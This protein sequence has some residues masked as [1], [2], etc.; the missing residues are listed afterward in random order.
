M[1][2]S[3]SHT[4]LHTQQ[5]HSSISGGKPLFLTCSVPRLLKRTRVM[6]LLEKNCSVMWLLKVMRRLK[7]RTS[8][9]E[10]LAPARVFFL[11]LICLLCALPVVAAEVP[12]GFTVTQIATGMISVTRMALLPDGRILVCEQSGK[13]RVIENGVLR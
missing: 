5:F 3:K 13:I 9:E 1:P 10:G 4:N 6:W 8:W 12:E 2:R 7:K 11:L